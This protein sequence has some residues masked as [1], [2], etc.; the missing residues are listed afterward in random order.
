MRVLHRNALVLKQGFEMVWAV[1]RDIEDG[2]DAHL[3]EL[4]EISRV[5][6]TTE[7]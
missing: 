6:C 1:V 3:P 4:G 7:D 2:C 5:L